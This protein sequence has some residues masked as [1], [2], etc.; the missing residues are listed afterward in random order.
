M[1]M[2]IKCVE[3]L[4]G[5][6]ANV[7]AQNDDE[8]TPLHIAIHNYIQQTIE[9]QDQGVEAEGNEFDELKR[10]IKELLFNGADRN[11]KGRFVL[12]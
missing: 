4:I 10:I 1:N 2:Q 12:S 11:I 6:G 9:D 5:R 8:H 7:N 3:C